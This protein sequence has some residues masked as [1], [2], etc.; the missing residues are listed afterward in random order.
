MGPAKTG[1]LDN[2]RK[3]C[4]G[5]C[6]P[7]FASGASD[8]SS[9]R[10]LLCLLACWADGSVPRIFRREDQQAAPWDLGVDLSAPP[11]GSETEAQGCGPGGKPQLQQGSALGRVFPHPQA[12]G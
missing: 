8:F 5:D 11:A 12:P 1:C 2:F 6:S 7:K 9:L 3:H 4:L 10:A